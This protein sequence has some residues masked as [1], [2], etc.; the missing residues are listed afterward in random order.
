MPALLLSLPYRLPMSIN[1]SLPIA[2]VDDDPAMRDALLDYF[3]RA[4]YQVTGYQN[5]EELLL[6]LERQKFGAIVCDLKMPKMDG[7]AVL[8]ALQTKHGAPPLIMVTAHGNIPTAVE[9]V[10]NGAYDFIAKPF[11]PKDLQQMLDQALCKHQTTLGDEQINKQPLGHSQ[12]IQDFYQTLMQCAQHDNNVILSG[13]KGVDKALIA[14]TLHQYSQRS[15]QSFVHVNCA[16]LSPRFFDKTFNEKDNV[17]TQAGSGSLFLENLDELPLES[18]AQ[19]LE[20]LTDKVYLQQQDRAHS[21]RLI[22]SLVQLPEREKSHTNLAK[23]CALINQEVLAIPA[24][25]A[26]KEDVFELFNLYITQSAAHYQVAI[27]SLSEQ[28]IVTLSSYQWPGN[29][30]QLRQIAEQFVLLN[31]NVE[32]SIAHLLKVSPSEVIN[33]T[34][35]FDKDLRTLMH[36]FERQLITQAMIECAGNISEVCELL[37]TPRRTLNEK[38]LKYDISRSAFLPR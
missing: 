5:G 10:K 31:R 11:N 34:H 8:K 24:L 18:R 13:E 32:T 19:L 17:F 23:I 16:I 7:M 28:D 4:N 25:R 1:H 26:H 9:A 37:K 33:M 38:L 14:K 36:D 30:A 2:I 29:Q 12:T 35:Q 20:I 27:P 3:S 22:C 21:P 6:A 15:E